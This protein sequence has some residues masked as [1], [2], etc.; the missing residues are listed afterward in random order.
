MEYY[1][2]SKTNEQALEATIEKH[3]TGICLE[4][5]KDKVQDQSPEW[6]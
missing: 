4:D 2:V 6:Y 1:M 3:L 5:L